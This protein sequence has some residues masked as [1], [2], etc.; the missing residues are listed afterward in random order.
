MWGGVVVSWGEVLP[1]MAQ[2]TTSRQRTKTQKQIKKL[3]TKRFVLFF[4]SLSLFIRNFHPS[5]P[6]LQ[7]DGSEPTPFENPL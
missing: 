3:P 1:G 6:F 4:F 7:D 5:A 2:P